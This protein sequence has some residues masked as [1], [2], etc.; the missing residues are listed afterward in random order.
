MCFVLLTA[1]GTIFETGSLPVH[2]G[3]QPM[4]HLNKVGQ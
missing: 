2:R 4:E 3:G 1:N